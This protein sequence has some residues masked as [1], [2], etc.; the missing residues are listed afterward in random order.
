MKRKLIIA[1]LVAATLALV[2]GSATALVTQRQTIL[3]LRKNQATLIEQLHRQSDSTKRTNH[4]SVVRLRLTTGELGE[5]RSPYAERISQLGLRLGR[6]NAI[7][8]TTSAMLLDT[9]ALAIPV[10]DS[11]GAAPL[12]PLA[13]SRYEW[14]DSW[15]SLRAD[16]VGDTLR[17]HLTSC[18]TLLQV[19]HRV[20]YR[21]WIFRWG[22]KAIR[23]EIRSS[24]PHTHLVYSEYIEI[25][26]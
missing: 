25:E 5:L 2:L 21:W 14:S 1:A 22:T 19:V 12:A 8:Q 10:G 11:I 3:R 17:W 18:D 23:Q 15:V 26:N 4:L 6:I 16:L 20:P 24:N 9:I 13:T 7:S